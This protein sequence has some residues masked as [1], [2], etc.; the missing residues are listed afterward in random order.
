MVGKRKGRIDIRVLVT[1]RWAS[2][3]IYYKI[4]GVFWEVDKVN[5]LVFLV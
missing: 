3:I 1:G 5:I 4:C 2:K